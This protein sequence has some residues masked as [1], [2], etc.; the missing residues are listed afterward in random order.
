[1][2]FSKVK[3]YFAFFKRL[4]TTLFSADFHKSIVFVSKI[5][6]ELI[7]FLFLPIG[8]VLFLVITALKPWILIRVGEMQSQ[9]MGHF[10]ANMELYLCEKELKINIPNKPYLD[11]WYHNWPLSNQQLATMWNRVLYVGPRW[12]LAPLD[13]IIHWLS[14]QSAH[15]V[16]KPLYSDA[17]VDNLL[18][19]TKNHLNFLPEEE[20]QGVTEL[21]TMGI[22]EGASF[23]VLIVRDSAY[24]DHALPWRSWSYHNYRDCDVQNYILA[25]KELADRGYYVIRMGAFVKKAMDVDHPMIIDYATNGMRN[26]FMDIYLGAKCTFCISNGTGFDAIPRNFR[27]PI[28]FIDHL[29]LIAIDTYNENFLVTTKNHWLRKENRFMTFQEIFRFS[30][31]GGNDPFAIHEILDVDLIESTPE[32]IKAAVIEMEER[33]SGKWQTSEEDEALQDRFWE[34]WPTDNFKYSVALYSNLKIR[35]R[36]GTDFL[37]GSKNLL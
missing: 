9:R 2:I 5:C 30:T 35:S 7:N 36:M 31:H 29:P 17:D 10:S 4:I 8:I 33:L 1:M 24:L 28:L 11:F 27:K 34:L 21:Q 16:G 22:P 23:V 26:D 32:E 15:I 18:S 20:Q 37:R 13:D 12:L 19:K 14:D 25:A 6:I 3:R